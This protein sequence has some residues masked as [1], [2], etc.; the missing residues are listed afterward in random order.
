MTLVSTWRLGIQT[1]SGLRQKVLSK[2]VIRHLGMQACR[3]QP[4][5]VSKVTTA[6]NSIIAPPSGC[7]TLAL[8]SLPI[9]FA[10]SPPA[11]F[12]LF[13]LLFPQS[14]L[15]DFIVILSNP[16]K[17]LPSRRESIPLPIPPLLLPLYP[18]IALFSLGLSQSASLEVLRESFFGSS[19]TP[20]CINES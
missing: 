7:P 16:S 6:T 10:N 9:F 4:M 13:L 8:R 3:H 5:S 14:Y 1:C 15:S 19:S 20:H 18:S 12:L 11:L 17:C 2:S